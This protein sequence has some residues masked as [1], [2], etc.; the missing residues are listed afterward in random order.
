MT[1]GKIND[2]EI[3]KHLIKFI[4]NLSKTRMIYDVFCIDLKTKHDIRWVLEFTIPNTYSLPFRSYIFGRKKHQKIVVLLLHFPFLV[5]P[6]SH[7]MPNLANNSN[8]LSLG[9]VI[10]RQIGAD[11]L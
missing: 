6:N 2:L 9:I 5:K 4:S 1:E 8:N 3:S 7:K 10:F 11:G